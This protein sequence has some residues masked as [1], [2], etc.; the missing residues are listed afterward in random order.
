MGWDRR[1]VH[2]GIAD[3]SALFFNHHHYGIVLN[4]VSMNCVH[5]SKSVIKHVE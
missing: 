3:I 2:Q 5:G 4:T 1:W